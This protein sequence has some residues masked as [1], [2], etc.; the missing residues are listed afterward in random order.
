MQIE[1]SDIATEIYNNL[2]RIAT[3]KSIKDRAVIDAKYEGYEEALCDFI[4]SLD[5]ELEQEDNQDE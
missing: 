3:N 5:D 4:K 1:I 2:H